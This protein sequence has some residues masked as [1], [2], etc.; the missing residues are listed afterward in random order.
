MRDLL[1]LLFE[2]CLYQLR[3]AR[4]TGRDT[5]D[6]GSGCTCRARSLSSSLLPPP[7]TLPQLTNTP[8]TIHVYQYSPTWRAEEASSPTSPQLAAALTY[9]P[10]LLLLRPRTRITQPSLHPS[11][12][13]LLTLTFL[14]VRLPQQ[15]P[16]RA[17][18]PLPL[19]PTP[20]PS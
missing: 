13:S 18:L 2:L 15:A 8:P 9:L 17:T 11:H 14:H 12:N 3:G 20:L 7:S 4:R 1:V 6:R 10:I 5:G 19:Q 16:P